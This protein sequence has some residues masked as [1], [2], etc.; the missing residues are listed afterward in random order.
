VKRLAL[1]GSG[2]TLAQ[3]AE[4]AD[5]RARVVLAP[6]ARRAMTASRKTV[7]RAIARGAIVYG[8]N[9]GFGNF[10]DVAIPPAQLAELQRNLVRSHSAGV[11]AALPDRVVRAMMVL[12]ANA[13]A[14]GFS[15][16]RVSTV[17]KYL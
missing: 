9:T 2:L 7:E 16:I 8:V 5:R 1:T 10:A 15:G 12:R 17:E 3:L 11:G 14:K 13:L 6:G 4:A